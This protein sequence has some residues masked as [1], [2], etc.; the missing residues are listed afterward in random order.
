MDET[1]GPNIANC[2]IRILDKLSEPPLNQYAAD[3]RR[4]CRA[5]AGMRSQQDKSLRSLK[6]GDIVKF[7]TP[8]HF[9]NG[10]EADTF[11]VDS[12]SPLRFRA[13][14]R[15][16]FRCRISTRNFKPG[17]YTIIPEGGLRV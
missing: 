5:N 12:V 13:E 1:Q 6:P 15:L 16:G 9:T 10:E 7:N 4:R 14:G 17:E 8:L 11:I 2:P 3:W